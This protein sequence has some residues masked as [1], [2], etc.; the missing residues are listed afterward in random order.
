MNKRIRHFFHL[1]L[2]T[3]IFGMGTLVLSSCQT[4]S[5]SN[6]E[7]L[8]PHPTPYQGELTVDEQ[9]AQRIALTAADLQTAIVD[10]TTGEP[11]RS[12]VFGVY[13]AR[14]SDFSGGQSCPSAACYRVDVYNYALNTTYS[15]IVDLKQQQTL[16]F[17]SLLGVQPEIPPHLTELAVQ[18][19]TTSPEVIEALGFDPAPD[20]P[21]MPNVKTALNNTACERSQH[22]CVAPTFLINERALWAIVDLT[23]EEL[24]GVRWTELGESAGIA[25]T[26]E[27]LAF[28]QIFENYC[29]TSQTLSR[30]GWSFAYILSSSDGLVL[31]DVVFNGRAVLD[32]VKLVD[33]HVNY[34][35][36]GFGYSDAIG[37]PVFSSASVV[38]TTPPAVTPI[39]ENDQTVGFALEQDYVHSQ[40]PNP[41]NYR[42]QQRFEFYTDGR[43]RVVAIN[44]GR[45]C[46]TNGTYRPIL[47]YQW[48][49]TVNYTFAE[50]TGERWQAWATEQWQQQ[51]E[52]TPYTAEGYQY[53]LYQ[54]DGT[55]YYIEPNQGQFPYGGVGDQAYTY[56]TTYKS[57]EGEADLLTLGACCNTDY[58]QGPEQF[59]NDESLVEAG[60]V[61]WYVP[62]LDN[63]NEVGEEYC[64]ADTILEN[65]LYQPQ[66]WPCAAGP[67]FIPIEQP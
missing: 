2:L 67:L 35:E 20:D 47:R 56:L 24:V 6:L 8:P 28:E 63:S 61:M 4:T 54:A 23:A 14:E 1:N 44:L 5:E 37:C 27:S 18:I 17:T 50:W 26:E 43:F 53:Q 9:R 65:G 31:S 19:A 51:T 52:E 13:P 30:D 3:I 55:G 46:G 49:A 34:S 36:D 59:I 33:W 32:N 60:L 64:W 22:L 25:I 62:Q 39:Q 12:E 42:Y 7:P 16:Q 45:G 29:Q 10:T 11:L 21:T 41:C 66:V 57:A 48:P 38:A 58:Q 40:W 15:L